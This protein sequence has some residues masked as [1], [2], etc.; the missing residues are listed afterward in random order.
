[1]NFFLNAA[2]SIIIPFFPPLATNEHSISAGVVGLIMSCSSIGSFSST[3]TAGKM[4]S[5]WGK[6]NMMVIGLIFQTLVV[7]MFGLIQYVDHNGW[8]ITLAVIS[9]LI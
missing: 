6:K 5:V 1:M 4:M 3:F 7:L 2:V 9:R 8:F